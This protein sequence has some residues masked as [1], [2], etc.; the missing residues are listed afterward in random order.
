MNEEN[1]AW[2][3]FSD[4]HDQTRKDD[5]LL[6]PEDTYYKDSTD[7]WVKVT[8]IFECINEARNLY[9]YSDLKYLGA[10]DVTTKV[11]VKAGSPFSPPELKPVD[12][13]KPAIKK[14]KLKRSGTIL[15]KKKLIPFDYC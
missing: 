9:K 12:L 2:A 15:I 5:H 3:F 7:A 14:K 10:V 11:T 8:A 1:I 6:A 13:E 4:Q